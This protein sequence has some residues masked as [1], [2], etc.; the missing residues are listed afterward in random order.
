MMAALTEMGYCPARIGKH[1]VYADLYGDAELPWVLFR[2]NMD[3]LPVLEET[4]IAYASQN[5]GVL[6]WLGVG[7]TSSLHNSKFLVP[8]EVLPLGVD[9]WVRL[10]EYKW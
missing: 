2:S 3:A 7:D 5:P 9:A 1:G 6:L 10:A 4:E 8:E